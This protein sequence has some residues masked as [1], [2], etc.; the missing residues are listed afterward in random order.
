MV[1]G[2]TSRRVGGRSEICVRQVEV[3]FDPGVRETVAQEILKEFS[4]SER[5]S[6]GLVINR[7]VQLKVRNWI[8][9]LS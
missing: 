8:Q 9:A 7:N 2:M 6:I 3:A 4:T 1:W 5:M